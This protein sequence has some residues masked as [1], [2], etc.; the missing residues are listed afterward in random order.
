MDILLNNTPFSVD[1]TTTYGDLI[2]AKNVKS[3]GSDY[4][5][6]VVNGNVISFRPEE[7]CR[8]QENDSVFV[9]KI[10]LGG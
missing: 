9:L 3:D 1:E 6:I 7:I 2:R 10:P 8:L 4:I 5:S